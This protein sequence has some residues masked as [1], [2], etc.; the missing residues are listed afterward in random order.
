MK[1]AWKAYMMAE[2]MA[3]RKAVKRDIQTEKR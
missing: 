3:E 1:V 2:K